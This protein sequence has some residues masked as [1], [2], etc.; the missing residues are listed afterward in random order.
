MIMT[1]NK[2]LRSGVFIDG[3]NIYWGSLN[4][5]ESERWFVDYSK[6]MHHLKGTYQPAFY[7]YFGARDDAPKTEEFERKAKSQQRKYAKFAGFGYDVITKPLKY[8]KQDDGSVKTKGDMDIELTL[9][10][11]DSLNDIDTVILFGGDCD[12]LPVVERLHAQ[13]KFVRIYS[14]DK[15]LSWELRMFAMK[16]TRCNFVLLDGLRSELAYAPLAKNV[17]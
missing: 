11:F 7:R 2:K 14:F 8:I 3:S 4:M 13:G 16:N 12:Y 6:L 10:I 15:L 9:S 17:N 5:P 1:Y